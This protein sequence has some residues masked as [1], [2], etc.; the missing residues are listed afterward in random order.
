[1]RGGCGADHSG[2]S[3]PAKHR[4]A[5]RRHDA[6]TLY[7]AGGNSESG[8]AVSTCFHRGY[9]CKCT[10]GEGCVLKAIV[11]LPGWGGGGRGKTMS[12]TSSSTRIAQPPVDRHFNK[13]DT[14]CMKSKTRRRQDHEIRHLYNALY[15]P[16]CNPPPLAIATQKSQINTAPTPT[17]AWT[18]L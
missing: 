8:V 14:W 15:C 12:N 13:G 3:M 4:H 10:V 16:S 11:F 7:K 1:M 9:H 17:V 18:R 5:T 6:C 2:P